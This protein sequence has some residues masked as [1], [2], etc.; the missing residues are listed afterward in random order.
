VLSVKILVMFTGIIQS[1]GAITQTNP[2]GADM[3]LLIASEAL[4]MSDVLQSMAF[5]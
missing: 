4:N 1:V 3:H 2:V 5:A